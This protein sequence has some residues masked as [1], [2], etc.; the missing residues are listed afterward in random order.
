MTTVPSSSS[1]SSLSSASNY[2]SSPTQPTYNSSTS[3]KPQV[4]NNVEDARPDHLP[5]PFNDLYEASYKEKFKK[6]ETDFVRLLMSKYF[7]KKNV[8]RENI[9]D[10]SIAIDGEIIKSSRWPCTRSN[11]DPAQGFEDQ[12]ID[13]LTATTADHL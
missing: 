13:S 9:F 5:I 7:S 2:N 1:T 10:E 3:S 11:S 12:S 6:Y 4:D 8:C